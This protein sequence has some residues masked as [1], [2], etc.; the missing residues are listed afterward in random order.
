MSFPIYRADLQNSSSP[1]LD[2]SSVVIPETSTFVEK[3]IFTLSKQITDAAKQSKKTITLSIVIEKNV[4]PVTAGLK[5]NF[6]DIS[7]IVNS[8]N[9]PGGGKMATPIVVDW[10]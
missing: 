9:K 5:V 1:K 10:S 3:R 8:G 2:L 6:P 4:E 7:F